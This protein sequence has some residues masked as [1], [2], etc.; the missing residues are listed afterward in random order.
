MFTSSSTF[1]TFHA[2]H[3][4]EENPHASQPHKHLR[5]FRRVSFSFGS[6]FSNERLMFRISHMKTLTAKRFRLRKCRVEKSPANRN[7]N[8]RAPPHAD[9]NARDNLFLFAFPSHS[10]IWRRREIGNLN[11]SSNN[12][13]KVRMDS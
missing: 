9:D 10:S 6:I 7:V 4:G 1:F 11:K 8:V 2:H 12:A 3:A 5:K 13:L